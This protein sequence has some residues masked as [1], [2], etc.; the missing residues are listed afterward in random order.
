[1]RPALP[2]IAV[3]ATRKTLPW[4]CE[5]NKPPAPSLSAITT[6]PTNREPTHVS[7][8][9]VSYVGGHVLAPFHR[10]LRLGLFRVGSTQFV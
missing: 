3:E 5:S 6:E 2:D 7:A 1:M 9:G 4:P 8:R 10:D